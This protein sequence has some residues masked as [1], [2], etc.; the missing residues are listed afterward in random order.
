MYFKC[1]TDGSFGGPGE[2]HGGL[3]FYKDGTPT[4]MLHVYTTLPEF[5]EMR[6]VGGEVIA[7]WS[8]IMSVVQLLKQRDTE[9]HG[10]EAHTLDLIYDYEG[11]GKWLRGQWKTNKT[12]TR[13]FVRN[14]K[15]LLSSV[16]NL[17]INY[18][19]VKGHDVTEGNN[20]ADKIANYNMEYCKKNE[21][22]CVC[23]DSL[24]KF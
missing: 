23:V 9:E 18:I 8:A 13:W 17:T 19:W 1:F 14:V 3:V 20:R 21:I 11:V 7:A 12:A 24:I 2:T 22:S 16:P 6:N 4:S 15:E 10:L 5:T